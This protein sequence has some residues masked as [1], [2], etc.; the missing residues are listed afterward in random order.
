M[1]QA[2]DIAEII[3][4]KPWYQKQDENEECALVMEEII[5][6]AHS[7]FLYEFFYKRSTECLGQEKRKP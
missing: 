6:A 7:L 2:E 4:R 1:S 5:I 3:L